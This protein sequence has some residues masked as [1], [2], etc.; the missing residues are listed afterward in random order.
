MRTLVVVHRWLGIV[1]CL[2]FAMWFA[3]GI[4]MHFVP[5]PLLTEAERVA[6][7]G[8]I[9]F[10]AVAHGPGAAVAASKLNGVTRAR[11]QQ[12]PDGAVYVV[13]AASGVTA[14]YASDLTGAG[15]A[16]EQ[17]ALAIAVDHARNRG[18]AAGEAPNCSLAGYDQWTVP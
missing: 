10:A 12:R 5:F 18:V 11:L 7:L 8:P 6:G 16:S 13:S 14:I 9:N 3:T 15:A 4:A 17:R 2:L 1:F